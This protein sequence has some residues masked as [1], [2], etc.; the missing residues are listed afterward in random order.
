MKIL[1]INKKRLI[2]AVEEIL[3]ERDIA[4]TVNSCIEMYL[5]NPYLQIRDDIEEFPDE[6]ILKGGFEKYEWY[7]EENMQ[8]IRSLI[9][10]A[11]LM[12]FKTPSI[13]IMV[14]EILDNEG[15]NPITAFVMRFVVLTMSSM[16]KYDKKFFYDDP[17]FT[18]IKF[19]STVENMSFV[20]DEQRHGRFVTSHDICGNGAEFVY[21]LGMLTEDIM[22]PNIIKNKEDGG[23]MLCKMFSPKDINNAKEIIDK[24]HGRVLCV[25]TRFGYL[26]YLASKKEDVN[27]IKVIIEAP[28][29]KLFRDGLFNQFPNSDKISVTEGP[30]EKEIEEDYDT[31]I[32]NSQVNPFL[33]IKL[34]KHEKESGKTYLWTDENNVK[35]KIKSTM[36]ILLGKETGCY[37]ENDAIR[38]QESEI[39]DC[40][41]EEIKPKVKDFEIRTPDDIRKLFSYQTIGELF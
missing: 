7:K 4:E 11:V 26:E 14:N 28:Y 41:L 36:F 3:K 30:W 31:I 25:G 40:L 5:S 39:I 10:I 6:E 37:E 15:M 33:Y 38:T 29:T 22:L 8:M 2:S 16:K 35:E 21:G 34:K 18:D 23:K 17:F 1:A 32:I 27:S 12:T 9:A 19:D 20:M 13:F 24:I